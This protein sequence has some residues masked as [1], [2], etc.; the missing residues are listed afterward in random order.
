MEGIN[1][2]NIL[3]KTTLIQWADDDILYIEDMVR[4]YLQPRK[5][6]DIINYIEKTR[7]LNERVSA[8]PGLYN[9]KI[10]PYLRE[11][12]RNFDI[13]K[14]SKSMDEHHRMLGNCEDGTASHQVA[15]LILDC[16]QRGYCK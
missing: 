13:N 1:L 3:S 10:T 15:S 9:Y 4:K 7:V 12:I 2:E 8:I 5:K 16:I 6:T 11:I 14:F